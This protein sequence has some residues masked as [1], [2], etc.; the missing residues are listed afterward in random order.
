MIEITE[1]AAEQIRKSGNK[2]LRLAITSGGC[3]GYR[4]GFFQDDERDEQDDLVFTKDDVEIVVDKMSHD[5]LD[6][7]IVDFKEDL[8]GSMFV[9]QNPNAKSGCGC[10][11]SFSV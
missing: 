7:S 5:I 3:S 4:Y 8:L 1:R 11:K 6:G 10:G 2:S 9:V